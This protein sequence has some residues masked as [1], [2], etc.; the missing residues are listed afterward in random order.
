LSSV[1]RALEGLRRGSGEGEVRLG[2]VEEGFGV[3][4]GIGASG[5]E[6]LD[7]LRTETEDPGRVG[8]QVGGQPWL[9]RGGDGSVD[10]CGVGVGVDEWRM[11]VDWSSQRLLSVSL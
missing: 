10:H 3:G 8:P 7:L 6:A 4:D 5:A 2:H 1:D 11:G 9:G